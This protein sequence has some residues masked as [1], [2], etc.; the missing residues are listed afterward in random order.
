MHPCGNMDNRTAVRPSR[1]RAYLCATC[2]NRC[3][4]V[5]E[6]TEQQ[7]AQCICG[8][9]LTAAL[10][11]AGQYALTV[12]VGLSPSDLRAETASGLRAETDLGYGHS[13]GYDSTHGGPTGPGDAP[14]K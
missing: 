1:M 7:H 4:V 10:L 3:L 9:N 8:G 6:E 12:Q 14:A 13:H 2:A 5:G 11:S